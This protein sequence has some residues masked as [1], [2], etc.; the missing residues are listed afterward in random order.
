M[1]DG[2][3]VRAVGGIG[4]RVGGHGRTTPDSPTRT[5]T[6]EVPLREVE[7]LIECGFQAEWGRIDDIEDGPLVLNAGAGFGS[8]WATIT[9][10]GK[11]Y[12]ISGPDLVSAFLGTISKEA[13]A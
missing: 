1:S 6:L 5:L 3:E 2:P 9:Y 12:A 8:A 7:S 13:K 4:V 11:K 10:A